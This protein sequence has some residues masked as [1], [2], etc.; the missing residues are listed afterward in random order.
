MVR[1]IAGRFKHHRLRTL[2]GLDTRPTSDQLKETLFNLI[3]QEVEDCRFLD[4]FSGSG[5]VGIEALSRGARGVALIESAPRAVQVIQANLR[6]LPPD[7]R[8]RVALLTKPVHGSIRILQ[9][10][11]RKFD[12][13]FID[14]PYSAVQHYP[15][16]LDLIHRCQILVPPAWVILEHSKR[17]TLPLQFN[18]LSRVR[19]VRQGDSRL[20]L[21]RVA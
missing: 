13:V 16:T 20:S 2:K 6:S 15:R 9:R 3:G 8:H 19:E 5:N 1:V 21:Y 11:G 14:P 7:C 4:C 18:D 10:Q 12:I 17:L